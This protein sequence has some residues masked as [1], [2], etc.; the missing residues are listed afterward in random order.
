MDLDWDE[1]NEP[2][3]IWKSSA[4]FGAPSHWEPGANCP[5]CPP[6][7]PP[8]QQHCTT[9]NMVTVTNSIHHYQHAANVHS[10]TFCNKILYC[11]TGLN[12]IWPKKSNTAPSSGG[13]ERRVQ[14]LGAWSAPKY[15][16]WHPHFRSRKCIVMVAVSCLK[17]EVR[18]KYPEATLGLEKHLEI[19]KELIRECVTVPGCCCCMPLL[20][21]HLM[22]SCKY[23]H[24]NTLL[25]RQRP[26]LP[27][28][29]HCPVQW[30]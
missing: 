2:D 17:L 24:K 26:P 1:N 30:H 5:C 8:C 25:S 15:L 21:N 16:C 6:P 27:I 10:Q 11:I 20:Y 23:V 19:S 18:T 14:P 9:S 22:D 7:P 4:S 12:K 13:L 29:R 28:I 3:L